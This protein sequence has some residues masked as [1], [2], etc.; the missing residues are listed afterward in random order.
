MG[1]FSRHENDH[2]TDDGELELPTQDDFSKPLVEEGRTKV[3]GRYTIDDAIELMRQLPDDADERMMVVV[4]K[5]LE[6]A[7]IRT[8]DVLQDAEHKE[9]KIRRQ[10]KG[11]EQEISDLQAQIDDRQKRLAQLSDS[12]EELT[13]IKARFKGASGITATPPTEPVAREDHTPEDTPESEPLSALSGF[14]LEGEATG[15]TPVGPGRR[16]RGASR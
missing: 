11:I 3:A 15:P 13:Q 1:L 16:G 2:E 4:C 7:H 8:A 10:H 14:E 6:S 9:Q 12:L 5:T